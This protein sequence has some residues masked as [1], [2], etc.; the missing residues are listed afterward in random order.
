MFEQLAL[1]VYYPGESLLHRLRARTK[2]I[3][4]FWL[5]GFTTAA[6]QR[7]WQIAPYILLIALALLT[8]ALS[9][10]GLGN[11]WR[12][13]RL[14]AL[15][16]ILG[17]VPVVL[18]AEGDDAPLYALGPLIV[19]TESVWLGIRLVIVLLSLYTLTLLLTMTTTPV[20]LVEGLALLLRPLR[21]LRLPIDEF[22]LM[23]L[24]ALRFIPTLGVE[25]ETLVKAQLA[26]GAD[27]AHGTP[28]QRADSLT[29]LIVPAFQAVWRR[30]DALGA[31]LDARGYA[32]ASDQT[33]LYEGPFGRA[34]YLTL[35]ML[36]LVSIGVL[37]V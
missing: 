11:V 6:N 15:L 36:V 7:S 10:V 26:R 20:A 25:I 22:A 24:L 18:L 17:M 37:L 35:G 21:R 27:F 19:T 5:A 3:A 32:I 12:R 4:L 34:D 9:G 8:A 28:R 14:L 1:G 23:T 30:A 2:L 33:M 31:A 13:I 16:T 29:A